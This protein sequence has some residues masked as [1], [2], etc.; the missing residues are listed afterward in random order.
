MQPSRQILLVIQD[1]SVRA[2]LRKQMK[3]LGYWVAESRLDSALEVLT[4]QMPDLLFLG[5]GPGARDFLA[6]LSRAALAASP[7]VIV[8][9]DQEALTGLA[10]WIDLGASDGLSKPFEA[11]LV[12]TRSAAALAW[13]QLRQSEIETV[14][15]LDLIARALAWEDIERD[16]LL[17]RGG[18]WAQI[19]QRLLERPSLESKD[20][21]LEQLKRELKSL[22]AQP[23]V[24]G[25]VLVVEDDAVSRKMLT[26]HLEHRGYEVEV[27]EDGL[28]A[29]ELLAKSSFDAI[30]LDQMMPRLDGYGVLQRLKADPVLQDV[31][32]IVI[33][34][35]EAAE[36]VIR[37]IE[38]GAQDHLVKPY[39]VRLLDARLRSSLMS[40]KMRD[41][42]REYIRGVTTLT[43][44]AAAI[45]SEDFRPD[46]LNELALRKDAIGR[47]GRVFQG[48][49][50]EILT[51]QNSLK[52]QLG[53]LKG[54]LDA[55]R[56]RAE[57]ADNTQTDYSQTLE[58]GGLKTAGVHIH[59]LTSFR[60]GTGTSTVTANLG[61]QLASAGYQVAVLDFALENPGLHSLFG[62]SGQELGDGV[63]DLLLDRTDIEQMAIDLTA[64]LGIQGGG[65]LKLIPASNRIPR[66]ARVL[67]QGYE[68]HSLTQA[69]DILVETFRLDFLL[70][71]TQAG[72]NEELVLC[73]LLAHSVSLLLRADGPDL[74]GAGVLFQVAQK[75]KVDKI[76]LLVNQ[77]A[78]ET[79]TDLLRQRL[80][81][82]FATDVA[83]LLPRFVS[84]GEL[85]CLRQPDSPWVEALRALTVRL[86]QP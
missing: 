44:A 2:L 41:Q 37:L 47:L 26:L 54:E 74:E 58:S 56:G 52:R 33:S 9:E 8:V 23:E 12:R 14:Q 35:N 20:H 17:R 4:S 84:E 81:D 3:G 55:A 63:H 79:D 25:R 38:M 53:E 27:A 48:M 66:L 1:P 39:N 64:S 16:L 51:R 72:L 32:V 85:P 28:V 76:H 29:M 75:L 73:L 40:K 10:H 46:S 49:A 59:V 57:R 86:L 13:S 78:A 7:A 67:R 18:A 70:I 36:D 31:P 45:E 15:G 68:P 77:V 30:L 71:D 83:A 24:T 60:G 42:E 21:D 22:E 61:I 82:T 43:Q 69:L 19:A 65:G 6:A 11:A 62:L 5:A 34:A 50:R 80:Q